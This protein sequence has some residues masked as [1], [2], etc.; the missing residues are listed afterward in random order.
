[1][2]FG[3]ECAVG[4]SIA[5]GAACRASTTGDRHSCRL[6]LRSGLHGRR[7]PLV[8]LGGTRISSQRPGGGV[9]MADTEGNEFC[10]GAL[11][12]KA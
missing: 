6:C 8:A 1:M 2:R 5:L 7:R 12:Q 11:A 4:L 9:T 10:I 3:L